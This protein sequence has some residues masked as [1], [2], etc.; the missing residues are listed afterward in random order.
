MIAIPAHRGGK[1]VEKR[2]RIGSVEGRADELVC[3]L[4]PYFKRALRPCRLR[5]GE[6]VVQT[7]SVL[8]NIAGGILAAG[9]GLLW[10]FVAGLRHEVHWFF[11]PAAPTH[12][13]ERRGT[14]QVLVRI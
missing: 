13:S 2:L 12:C 1:P 10:A 9:D 6:H 8:M 7:S 11:G 4:L 14:I 5:G 3:R